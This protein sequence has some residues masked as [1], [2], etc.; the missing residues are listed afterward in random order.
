M[1]VIPSGGKLKAGWGGGRVDGESVFVS[2]S[3]VLKQK[4][5]SLSLSHSGSND[6]GE[7]WRDFL[8]G[9]NFRAFWYHTT[10]PS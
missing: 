9:R 10:L 3:L 1:V 6:S 5:G 8:P 7:V 4:M 2:P